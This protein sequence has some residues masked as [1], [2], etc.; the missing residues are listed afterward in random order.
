MAQKSDRERG[1][2]EGKLDEEKENG[3][4]AE[5]TSASLGC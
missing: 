4:V 2:K 5:A 3:S 1:G